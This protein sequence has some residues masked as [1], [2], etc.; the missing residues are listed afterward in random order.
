MAEDFFKKVRYIALQSVTVRYDDDKHWVFGGVTMR[1]SPNSK[2][3]RRARLRPASAFIQFRRDKT[4][5]QAE[6]ENP[7]ICRDST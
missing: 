2:G 4:A 3:E 7:E 5:R 1:Y 6:S